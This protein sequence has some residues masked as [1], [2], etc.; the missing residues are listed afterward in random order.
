MLLWAFTR[1]RARAGVWRG[2]ED[3]CLTPIKAGPWQGHAYSDLGTDGPDLSSIHLM[4]TTLC[5]SNHLK[6]QEE[7]GAVGSSGLAKA[8]PSWGRA[9]GGTPGLEG[10]QAAAPLHLP[11]LG[12]GHPCFPEQK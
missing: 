9:A 6:H 4:S 10:Q 2:R 11:W 1:N 3:C 7:S 5:S 8:L 12:V